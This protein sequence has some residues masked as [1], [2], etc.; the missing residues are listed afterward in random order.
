MKITQGIFISLVTVLT[1]LNLQSLIASQ[2]FAQKAGALNQQLSTKDPGFEILNK[3]TTSINYTVSLGDTAQ[4]N[5]ITKSGTVPAGSPDKSTP[6]SETVGKFLF[7]KLN[8]KTSDGKTYNFIIKPQ[9]KTLY[10]TWNPAKTPSLYPQTGPLNGMTGSNESGYPI[11]FMGSTN[12]QK[13]EIAV[14]P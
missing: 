11:G 5:T 10:L 8:I 13:N 2:Q 9:R 4:A 3:S 6:K 7:A 12:V 1:L 14:T